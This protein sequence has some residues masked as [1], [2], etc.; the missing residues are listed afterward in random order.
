M[1]TFYQVLRVRPRAESNCR[2]EILQIS[3]LP[4]FY[5]AMEISLAFLTF[6]RKAVDELAVFFAEIE[7][8][9]QKGN[10]AETRLLH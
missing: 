8:E 1:E 10:A 6:V 9:A 5:V 2:I 4:L 7:L 3:E